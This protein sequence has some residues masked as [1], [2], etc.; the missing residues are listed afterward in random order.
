MTWPQMSQNFNQRVHSLPMTKGVD[1]LYRKSLAK[2]RGG[3]LST[4][5]A[6]STQ[7]NPVNGSSQ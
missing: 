7:D 3:V 1:A 6:T 4:R 2:S 5:L